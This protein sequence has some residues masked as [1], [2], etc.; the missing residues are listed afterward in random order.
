MNYDTSIQGYYVV[1]YKIVLFV[2]AAEGS[3]KS[4]SKETKRRTKFVFLKRWMEASKTEA[5]K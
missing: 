4:I 5:A 3:L 2:S 1:I